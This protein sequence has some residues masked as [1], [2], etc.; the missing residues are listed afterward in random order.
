MRS[1][2]VALVAAATLLVSAN[3]VPSIAEQTPDLVARSLTEGQNNGGVKRSLRADKTAYEED[4]LDS[5]DSLDSYDSYDKKTEER[6]MGINVNKLLKLA[7]DKNSV[8]PVN[9]NNL[10]DN[11][12]E[13]LIKI[14]AR[15]RLTLEQFAN[16]LGMKRVDDTGHRNF[17]AFEKFKRFF[18][19]K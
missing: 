3:A 1:Y 18:E 6:A 8:L 15:Q 2:Y 5:L 13:K 16:K 11:T 19:K 7:K 4:P 14:L 12:Q 9:F 10:A 17:K